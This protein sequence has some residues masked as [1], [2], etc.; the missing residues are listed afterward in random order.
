MKTFFHN[1]RAYPWSAES[2]FSFR[3]YFIAGETLYRGTSA[4]QYLKSRLSEG[5]PRE[6][7][8]ELDGVFSLIWE[9]DEDILLAVDRLRSLPLFYSLPD[10]ELW[11][12]DDV[13]ALAAAL[14]EASLFPVGEAEYF[15][16]KRFVTGEDT[17]LKELKQVPAG[18]YCLLEKGRKEISLHPYFQMTHR[19]FERNPAALEE[20]MREAYRMV[21]FRLVQALEGRTA[22]IP[23]SGGADSRMILSLLREQG[24]QKALCFTY[25]REGN[26]ES[27]IS[28]QTA[29]Y[30]GYPWVM[31]PYSNKM[32]REAWG[33]PW[34][35]AY[36]QY[37]FGFCSTPHVQDILAV[38][39]LHET[40]R[41]PSDSVFVPGHSGDL[42]A[43]SHITAD[44]L[45]P[46]MPREKF[47]D[48][49]V[50]KF[51]SGK[52]S[53]DMLSRLEARFP[54]RP[55]QDME[56]LA[57]Q[58]EWFNIQE[59]QGKFI[60]N[61][62]RAYEFLGYEWLI[63]LWDNALFSFWK[64]VPIELRY[65]RR[66]Y[67][68][69]ADGKELPSTNDASVKKTIASGVRAI[70]GIRD[71]ARRGTRLTRYF[72]SSL[73]LEAMFPFPEY[74]AACVWEQPSF[75]TNDLLCR[76]LLGRLRRNLERSGKP[77][78]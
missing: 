17:L 40:G 33:T 77:A 44:F 72:R 63:P 60:V 68:K 50:Q 70:P 65:Q 27:E 46:R 15:A 57:A 8:R 31:V 28:R 42:I 64:R 74:L 16:S 53:P 12:G 18:S 9:R 69:V 73:C 6:A 54:P 71:L 24:Y 47:L 19:D 7:F 38:K 14:P 36:F 23:L 25:G 34:L 5:D 2:P 58:S 76:E 55:P 11:A 20:G 30:Y 67:F 10:G 45:K 4:I 48:S 26:A 75:S 29:A 35:E 32:W 66:L 39:I 3:G 56:E 78:I 61:S 43:G 59:R 22:V 51:Y 41:L 21:G 1:G 37:A 49:V 52:A 62:V 13:R